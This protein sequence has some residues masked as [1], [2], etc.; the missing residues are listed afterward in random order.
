MDTSDYFFEL[1][2]RDFEAF[3]LHFSLLYY[4]F[5]STKLTGA[6]LLLQQILQFKLVIYILNL[7]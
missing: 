4:I 6:I 3:I 1:K 5:T 2:K 7:W